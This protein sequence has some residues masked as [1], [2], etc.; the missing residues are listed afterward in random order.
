ME[1]ERYVLSTSHMNIPACHDRSW[2][3]KQTVP[4]CNG[5][6]SASGFTHDH[7]ATVEKA[8]GDRSSSAWR[9]H[10]LAPPLTVQLPEHL[11][12]E[13]LF[14]DTVVLPI[15][16]LAGLKLM[17]ETPCIGDDRIAKRFT[18]QTAP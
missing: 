15:G 18:L 13:Q 9:H 4:P 11:T 10:T 7:R 16:P 1:E 6:S 3:Y 2:L 17:S 12:K 5:Q 8:F 14:A